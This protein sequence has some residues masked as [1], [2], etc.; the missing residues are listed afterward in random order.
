MARKIY[1]DMDGVLADFDGGVTEL[2]GLKPLKQGEHRSKEEDDLMWER[3]RGV[4][5]FYDRLE[6][7]PGAVELFR[8]L[9]ERYGDKCEILTGIPKPK[10]GITTAGEDK[11]AWAHRLLTPELK[12]NIVYR[13]EK[14]NFCTGKDSILIDDLKSNIDDWVNYGGTGILHISS[15]DTRLQLLEKDLL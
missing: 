3:V 15:E 11:I 8:E 12:V 9:Y 1:F 14:K 7:M 6:P 2:C 5:H 13:E 10:R 4:P